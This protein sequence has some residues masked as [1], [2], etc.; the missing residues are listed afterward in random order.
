[1]KIFQPKKGEISY[2]LR[3]F[4]GCSIGERAIVEQE[5]RTVGT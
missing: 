2:I 4:T 3:R 5:L 1:M